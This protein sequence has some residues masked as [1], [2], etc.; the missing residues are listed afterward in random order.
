M[1]ISHG[2]GHFSPRLAAGAVDRH[3]EIANIAPQERRA[4]ADGASTRGRGVRGAGGRRTAARGELTRAVY[5]PQYQDVK[6]PQ[7]L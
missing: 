2:E 1:I 6:Y 3:T 7:Q 5:R 4:R